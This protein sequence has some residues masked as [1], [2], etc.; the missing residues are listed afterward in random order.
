MKKSI[1][2][3]LFLTLALGATAQNKIRARA[4]IL[5][6]YTAI[7]EYVRPGN[8]GYL[9]DSVDLDQQVSGAL[10]AL[11][12]DIDLGSNFFLV[13]GFGYNR[14]GLASINYNDIFTGTYARAARQNYLGINI[15]V[16]YHYQPERSRFGFF[17]ATGPKVD[18][19]IGE[20]NFAEFSLATGS[21]YFHAFGHYNVVEFLWYTNPGITYSLGPGEL[22]FDINVLNGLSDVINDSYIIGKTTSVG[23]SFGYSFKLN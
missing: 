17:L 15:Q 20:P 6:T 3:L 22:Y 21:S 9:I 12:M 14:K 11:E 1:T 16:K 2:L 7:A 18:F 19:A 10:A 5:L 13:T 8:A 4:G 23:V